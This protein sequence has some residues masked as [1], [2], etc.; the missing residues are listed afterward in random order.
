[1][2]KFIIFLISCA[3]VFSNPL[4][5]KNK[6]SIQVLILSGRNNHDWEQTTRQLEEIFSDCE[7][8]GYTITL[9]PDTLESEDFRDIDV[10]L[11]N[12]NSWPENE[13]RWPEKAEQALSE[14]IKK[15]G[16]F[17]TFHASTSAFYEWSEFKKFTTGAW[18]MERTNHGKNSSTGVSIANRKHPVTKGMADFHIFDE[19]WID[20][21]IN[22]D[23]E[24]LGT[25]TNEK[26]KDE[27]I[28]G[29]PAIMISKYGKGRIFHTILGHDARA[30]RNT[31]FKQLL[32]RGTEWAA[33]GN[34]TQTLAQELQPVKANTRYHWQETNTTLALFKG[35]AVIWQFNFKTK[36]G[37]PFFHP[38]FVH[39]NNMTCV[40]P[41]DHLWHLGQ[42]FCWKYI[43]GVNYWEYHRGPFQSEGITEVKNI[44]IKKNIDFSAEI[45]LDIVYH[46][47]GGKDVLSEKRIIKV[48]PPK[49]D[50]RVQ[51]D[52]SFLFEAIADEVELNRT[53]VLGQ[54][55]GVS[56]G[57]YAG[58]SI[59]FS[60][61]FMDPYF[62]TPWHDNDSING[63][64]GNWLY[65][66]FTGIDGQRIGS[67]IM[68][69]P[70]SQRYGSAWYSVNSEIQPFYYFS[71][72][73][74]FFSPVAMKKGEKIDLNYRILHHP[75]N[76]NTDRLDQ[77][78][79]KYLNQ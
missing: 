23:F 60:Q 22:P 38:V 61:D 62:L 73:Y 13:V 59:R 26:L 21:E 45:K 4:V 68:V 76:T 64:Q 77:E 57:G 72:A 69:D 75:G 17:V 16:G 40:S 54:E 56:W 63:R 7:L 58:L 24:V 50:G 44:E 20:A 8:F 46:P 52:Y 42:W 37:R 49:P 9:Q 1:M 34:A 25:A 48:F 35:D 65:M 36:H 28:P 32:L 31:G 66:G 70:G 15:G 10:V 41:D 2:K 11:S 29:Q 39:R 12:W 5:A 14:F 67:Q 6:E 79:N 78:F 43:N 18:I 71:P 51:M 27:G 55:N 30:M 33:T 19:L 53:P 3:F 47:F 74:L